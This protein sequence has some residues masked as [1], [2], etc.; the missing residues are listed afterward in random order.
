M[1]SD[2]DRDHLCSWNNQRRSGGSSPRCG[3][4][5]RAAP[6][7]ESQWRPSCDSVKNRPLCA[8]LISAAGPPTQSG[9][10]GTPA[11]RQ[12]VITIILRSYQPPPNH[13]P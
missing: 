1:V 13:A 12:P 9:S 10:E 2:N 4:K 11:V 5:K 3:D 6:Q 7:W 8:A